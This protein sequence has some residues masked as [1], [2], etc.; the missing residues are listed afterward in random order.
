MI[1]KFCIK[2]DVFMTVATSLKDL[3]NLK[4]LRNCFF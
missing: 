3:N 2:I 4:V 1:S